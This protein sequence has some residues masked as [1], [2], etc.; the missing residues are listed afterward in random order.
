MASSYPGALDTVPGPGATLDSA[1]G[2]T[3]WH[4]EVNE[5]AL[6]T[7]AVLGLNPQGSAATV[8]ARL[9][10]ITN[11]ASTALANADSAYFQAGVANAGVAAVNAELG[12]NPSGASATVAD[13]LGLL[14]LADVPWTTGTGVVS[15]GGS[16]GAIAG[17]L[18]WRYVATRS[19]EWEVQ[20]FV[21]A[22]V[23][24]GI[25][26]ITLPVAPI[27]FGS[28]VGQIVDT[29]LMLDAGT[30][31][32]SGFV[33]HIPGGGGGCQVDVAV[34]GAQVAATSTVPFAWVPGDEFVASGRYRCS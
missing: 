23:T 1:S 34:G 3:A 15:F 11:T 10:T 20:A 29:C 9:T 2:H 16:S 24:A 25:L 13:R 27:E 14:G 17:N 32:Y 31:R 8:A 5:A 4:S 18:K 30:A 33:W 19:V 22:T 6:A 21:T 12:A 7:Q 26:V 28:N